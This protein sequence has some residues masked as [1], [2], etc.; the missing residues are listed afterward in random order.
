MAR[1]LAVVLLLVQPRASI[2]DTPCRL[3]SDSRVF[4]MSVLWS[5]GTSLRSHC[6][7]RP[8]RVARAAIS[9]VHI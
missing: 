6:D 1:S 2:D 5:R 4:S 9:W 7:I 3:D 8:F